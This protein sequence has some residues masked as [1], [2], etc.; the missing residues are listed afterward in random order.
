[1]NR[2]RKQIVSG[3]RPI[4]MLCIILSI[5]L[6]NTV[7]AFAQEK[8]PDRANYELATRWQSDNIENIVYD[9]S[10]SPNWLEGSDKFWYRF[11]TSEGINYYLVDPERRT[12]DYLFDNNKLAS[13]LTLLTNKPYDAKQLDIE[14]LNY[15]REQTA[16]QITIDSLQFRYE[17]S[18]AALSLIDTVRKARE[19][20]K[21]RNYS[22]DSTLVVFARNHN[23]FLMKAD[24]P[25]SVEFQLTTDGEKWY[26]FAS[27]PGDTTV[28]NRVRASA[29]WFRDS[30]KFHTVRRD[31]R[32]VSDLWVI[33][34]LTEPRPKLELYK[35]QVPGDKYIEQHELY[36]FDVDKKNR[37]KIEA[38][39]WKDQAIGGAYMTDQ[40]IYHGK[41]SDKI[42]F[43]RRDRAWKKIDL[44]V[45]NTETG[46]VKVLFSEES[47]PYFNVMDMHF[48][49]LN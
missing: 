38:D 10:V 13:Q 4:I 27:N 7:I 30:K 15:N 2:S 36:I 33:N 8:L 47:E 39:K 3:R 32:K 44:C 26:S 14:S 18:T 17:I 25:D 49:E 11:K 28:D 43:A 31:V 23:L 29:S 41:S 12:K 37:V 46:E 22:P 45:G 9:M 48:A 1:M 34:S 6:T 16:I 42:Y 24:D 5:L 20:K 21:W 40:G 35:Y 19:E